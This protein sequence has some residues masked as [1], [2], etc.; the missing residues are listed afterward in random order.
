MKK[1]QKRMTDNEIIKGLEKLSQYSGFQEYITNL[2]VDSVDLINRQSAEI[3][4]LEKAR[5][6]QGEFLAEERGQK[7]E[8][9]NK[10]STAKSEAYIEFAERL[11]KSVMTIFRM[12]LAFSLTILTIF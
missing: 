9:I 12:I 2:I 8:L 7:Y 6:R 10:L 4:K 11:K 5:Q 1:G 3:E